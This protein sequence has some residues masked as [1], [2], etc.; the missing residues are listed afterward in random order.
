MYRRPTMHLPGHGRGT[1]AAHG[2][3]AMMPAASLFG[4]YLG[5]AYWPSLE[6]CLLHLLA[7]LLATVNGK[8]V[9]ALHNSE[10]HEVMHTRVCDRTPMPPST[11]V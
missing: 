7:L 2:Y 3:G 11:M 4:Q 5:W 8:T 6:G 10:R 1:R 9:A